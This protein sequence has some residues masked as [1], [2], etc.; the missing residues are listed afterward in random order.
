M[1]KANKDLTLIDKLKVARATNNGFLLSP[2]GVRAILDME[3][4]TNHLLRAAER[5]REQASHLLN[6]ARRRLTGALIVL[7][8]DL[9]LFVAIVALFLLKVLP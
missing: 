6:S 5:D 4:A 2:G 1:N 3:T 7:G 8:L 9:S